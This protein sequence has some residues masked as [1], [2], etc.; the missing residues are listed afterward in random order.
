M[1]TNMTSQWWIFV[2]QWWIFKWPVIATVRQP[3]QMC[4][5]PDNVSSPCTLTS[6][7]PESYQLLLA[8]T[9]PSAF[10]SY[11]RIHFHITT[12]LSPSL[13]VKWPFFHVNLGGP[14]LSKLRMTE[15]VVSTEAIRRT[16]L[17]SNHHHQTNHHPMFYRPDT[18]SVPNQQC[19]STEGKVTHSKDLL[20]PN[21]AGVFQ[22]C[23][24]PLKA[25]G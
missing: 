22:L 20:N 7:Q 13:S 3:Q 19:Q 15:V 24:W 2:G 5:G 1:S 25:P 14:V 8:I 6:L 21:S 9:Q 18:L 16:K 10:T 17:Q 11:Q 12:L 23:L 4:R